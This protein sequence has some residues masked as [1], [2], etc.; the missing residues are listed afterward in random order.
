MVD[1]GSK[2]DLRA[3]PARAKRAEQNDTAMKR[4]KELRASKQRKDNIREQ[5]EAL[6][7]GQSDEDDEDEDERGDLANC[8]EDGSESDKDGTPAP[9]KK[10]KSKAGSTATTKT[11]AKPTARKVPAANKR[12]PSHVSTGGDDNTLKFQ[13]IAK[14]AMRDQRDDHFNF[15][16]K[17]LRMVW[18]NGD[19]HSTTVPTAQASERIAGAFN[20]KELQDL[21]TIEAEDLSNA[22]GTKIRKGTKE[23]ASYKAKSTPSTKR[24][25]RALV[26]LGLSW[27]ATGPVC[28]IGDLSYIVK[29]P[30]DSS[31]ERYHDNEPPPLVAEDTPTNKPQRARAANSHLVQSNL[32]AAIEW[33]VDS[34]EEESECN[35][36]EKDETVYELG[37][38]SCDEDGPKKKGKSKSSDYTG[39]VRAILEAT[40]DKVYAILL[41]RGFFIEAKELDELIARTWRFCATRIVDDPTLNC[42]SISVNKLRAIKYRITSWQGKLKDAI[43][44]KVV[45]EYGLTGTVDEVKAAVDRL[46][47]HGF[48]TR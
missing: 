10:G 13:L 2:R 4:L 1:S 39:P 28:S 38:T 8:D 45:S 34:E 48:H 9:P 18:E 47:D 36:I 19:M 22:K 25:D 5:H 29:A 15:S 46:L 16:L 43:K 20:D 3:D 26:S 14:I 17:E 6:S 27:A 23:H 44:P 21:G 12:A 40:L 42:Y 33:D 41:A 35:R 24:V 11:N 37:E 32:T 30:P 7:L 31:I